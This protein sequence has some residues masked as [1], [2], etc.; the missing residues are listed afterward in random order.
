MLKMA[1]T[2][3]FQKVLIIRMCALFLYSIVLG[4]SLSFLSVGPQVPEKLMRRRSMQMAQ[5]DFGLGKE[6]DPIFDPIWSSDLG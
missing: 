6:E 5:C 4:Y 2:R 3:H 1:A